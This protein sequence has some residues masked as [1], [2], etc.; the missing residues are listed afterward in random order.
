MQVA[1]QKFWIEEAVT[2][3]HQNLFLESYFLCTGRPPERQ[4]F[5]RGIAAD[6]FR[7]SYTAG[8]FIDGEMVGGYCLVLEPPLV[9]LELLPAAVRDSHPFLQKVGERNMIS[10]PML[11]LNKDLR[12]PRHSVYLWTDMLSSI[13]EF[14][15]THLLYTYQMHEK[16][17]WKLY[18]RGGNS[19][20]IYEG[21]LANGGL[22]GVDVVNV[23]N[24]AAKINFLKR[25]SGRRQVAPAMQPAAYVEAPS[26]QPRIEEELPHRQLAEADG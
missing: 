10:L 24:L 7:R 20:N 17:N 16:R 9:E 6:V 25:F 12:G 4:T 19:A 26:L 22:G 21:V 15:R 2:T 14:D 5:L 1:K 18:K 3:D 11:W 13:Y 8:Y 23:E